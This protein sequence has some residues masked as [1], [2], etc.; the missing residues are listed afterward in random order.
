MRVKRSQHFG[1]DQEGSRVAIASRNLYQLQQLPVGRAAMRCGDSE[2]GVRREN[3]GEIVDERGDARRRLCA[4]ARWRNGWRGPGGALQ[5]RFT[6]HPARLRAAIDSPG[7]VRLVGQNEMGR[8]APRLTSRN[9]SSSVGLSGRLRLSRTA[10]KGPGASSPSVGQPIHLH[11]A[12]ERQLHH[13]R[14]S[15]ISMRLRTESCS[16]SRSS[17][18]SK[19]LRFWSPALRG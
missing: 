11:D 6:R 17:S 8:P 3:A 2:E 9:E 13:W 7:F 5:F 14:F 1:A 16:S 10:S 12:E 15:S 19:S 4:G 18:T